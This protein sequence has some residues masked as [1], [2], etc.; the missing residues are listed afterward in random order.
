MKLLAGEATPGGNAAGPNV[1]G[2]ES[3]ELRHIERLHLDLGQAMASPGKPAATPHAAAGGNQLPR[4]RSTS[5]WSIAWPRSAI[6][7]T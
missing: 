3:F 2:I 4:A 6:T 7:W 1:A 5:T